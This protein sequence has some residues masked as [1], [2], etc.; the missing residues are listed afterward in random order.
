[1]AKRFMRANKAR[2]AELLD[3]LASLGRAR[4]LEDGKFVA[5]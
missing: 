3:T 4:Q 2:I 1:V 5:V